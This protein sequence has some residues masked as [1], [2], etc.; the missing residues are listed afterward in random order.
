M[1]TKKEIEKDGVK[2]IHKS[3]VS[4]EETGINYL[5]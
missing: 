1:W 2:V 5:P 3:E 4:E